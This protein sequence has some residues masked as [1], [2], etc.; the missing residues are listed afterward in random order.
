MYNSH[1]CRCFGA[2]N[3]T[4]HKAGL[5][6]A[7]VVV[8]VSGG[9]HSTS[10]HATREGPRPGAEG[11]RCVHHPVPS[12]GTGRLATYG[13]LNYTN[14]LGFFFLS[15]LWI[16]RFLLDQSKRTGCLHFGF[17]RSRPHLDVFLRLQWQ[18]PEPL[19]WSTTPRWSQL[20]HLR[21]QTTI[22][23]LVSTFNANVYEVR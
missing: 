7:H 22:R 17:V 20:W 19:S 3:P 16:S 18:S 8:I 2:I 11:D 13:H 15:F 12:G 1:Y 23:E 6:L 14:C 21:Q 9:P 4:S 10:H 5:M